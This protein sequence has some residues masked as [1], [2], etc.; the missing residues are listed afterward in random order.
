VNKNTIIFLAIVIVMIA[1]LLVVAGTL[2]VPSASAQIMHF[3]Q[4]KDNPTQLPLNNSSN[5]IDTSNTN[6]SASSSGRR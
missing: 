6:G 3:K 1:S 4:H 2:A 5:P